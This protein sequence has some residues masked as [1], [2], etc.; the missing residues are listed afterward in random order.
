MAHYQQQEF[1]KKISEKFPE[2]FR[3][4]KVLDIGSLDINGSNHFFLD[5]CNYIGLD[6]GEGPNVDVV[7]VA[8]LY[9]APDNYFDLIISTEVFEHD[10]FYQ[11][12]IQNIIRMLKPGGAFIFTCA[13]TGRPEHGTRQSDGSSAAPLLINISEEWSDYYKNLTEDDIS[14]IT[15]FREAF[16]D[17]IFEYNSDP[18]DLYFF[19]VKGGIRNREKYEILPTEFTTQ[20]EEYSDHIFVVDAWPDTEEKEND[21]LECIK[22]LKSFPGIQILLVTHYAIKPEI[23]KLVD[24][25]VFDKNNPILLNSEFN[26]HAVSSGRWIIHGNHRMDSEMPYHHDYAIWTSLQHAFNFCKYLGKTVIHFMEYD[27]LI[28]TFQFKQAFIDPMSY[29]DAVLYEYLDKSSL[30][31][32]PYCATYIF[33]IKTDIAIATVNQINS[34]IDYFTNKPHGWQLERVFFK[35]LRN[36]TSNYEIS[37]YIAND[38]ELNTQ[39]VWNRD[40]IVRDD[41]RFQSYLGV[42]EDD[43]LYLVLLSGFH[44]VRA[45]KDYLLE[46]KYNG[47][48]Q[49]KNLK[50][51]ETSFIN[52]GQYKKGLTFEL[53]YLG[54]TVLSEFLGEDLNAYR[55]MSQVIDY[56]D[57][58]ELSI[59]YNFVNGAYCEIENNTNRKYEV[60]FIDKSSDSTKFKIDLTGGSWAR[61]NPKY[62]IDWKIKIQDSFKNVIRE[63]ELDLTGKRVYIALESGSLGDTLAWFPYVEEFRKKHQCRVICSTFWNHFFEENYP[64]IELVSPGTIVSNLH[65][66]YRVGWFYNETGINYELNPTDFRKGPLQKTSADILGLEFKEVKPK[67]PYTKKERKKKVGLGIHSTAQAKYWNNSTGWQEVTDWLIAN[68][69]E[70][71]ILSREEDGYMGNSYPVGAKKFPSGPI[72]NVIE[73]LAECCAFIGISSGLT[74]LAWATD[75]PTIQISGFTEPFNEPDEGVI[76][77]SAPEETCSGCANVHRLDAGDWNWCPVHK[78][79]DR[80]FECSKKITSETVISKL[81]ELL[82]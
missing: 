37:K 24:Y 72:Q 55:K 44:E 57:S 82:K 74:W 50:I 2:Y 48:S 71:I 23:Q 80:Q 8:H 26:D 11:K 68:G 78:G 3:G 59:K 63:V 47:K 5:S 9:D 20:P 22:R 25:Y 77:I 19:G 52:L 45:N 65:A 62:F 81:E 79:T 41:A 67:I 38:N 30:Q 73:E 13:S 75:T 4:K 12:S 32:D 6:V 40:G 31:M 61:P 70:P 15:G 21:L 56:S 27:N 10:M 64:E 29:R 66:M 42:G 54:K 46:I 17:G 36:V 35:C 51:D 49:F 7:Q 39:A 28:D 1:C 18:G 43:N 69:Y 33:S 14:E 53:R 16:P 58:K 34:K 76:K 60:S